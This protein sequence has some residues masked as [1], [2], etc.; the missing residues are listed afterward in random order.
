MDRARLILGD[1]HELTCG[2]DCGAGAKLDLPLPLAIATDQPRMA[3]A[4]LCGRYH[5]AN[6]KGYKVGIY[7]FSDLKSSGG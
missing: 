3:E 5:G 2:L 1:C 6:E 7:I 4:I